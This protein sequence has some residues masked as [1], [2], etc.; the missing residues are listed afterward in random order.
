MDKEIN[1]VLLIDDDH[2]TNVLHRLIIESSRL[3]KKIILF[4]N[5]ADALIYLNGSFGEEHPKPDIIFLDIN[6]PGMTGW[7]FIDGYKKLSEEKKSQ[8]QLLMLST[9]SH[10]EDLAR[11]EQESIVKDYLY[12]PLTEEVI[13][14][15]ANK[16]FRKLQETLVPIT[17]N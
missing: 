10:P 14:H 5:G 6:M 7:E 15:V 12:K 4:D 13:H 17:I 8:T 11:A 16:H 3:V 9:S 1:C 2:P